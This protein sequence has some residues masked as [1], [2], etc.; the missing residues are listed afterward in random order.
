MIFK[1][2]VVIFI[3]LSMAFTVLPSMAEQAAALCEDEVKE[4]YKPCEVLS[5][6]SSKVAGDW[7]I[8]DVTIKD[9]YGVY[10]LSSLINKCDGKWT[11]AGYAGD[12]AT[13][14]LLDYYGVPSSVHEKLLG[15]E[16]IEKGEALLDFLHNEKP[17]YSFEFIRYAGQWAYISW[18]DLEMETEG[19]ALTKKSNGTW[20]LIQFGGGAVSEYEL[21]EWGVSP[22]E[23]KELLG[24]E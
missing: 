23:S 22:E 21:Q 19:I 16:A 10:D 6:N 24:I 4:L 8:I 14:D 13:A 20:D 17:G 7:A 3:L 1:K 9:E 15:S 2:L 11:V 12:G 5:I 18:R